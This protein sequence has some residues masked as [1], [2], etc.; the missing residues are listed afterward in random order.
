MGSEKKI[1]KL[2]DLSFID[3]FVATAVSADAE[4]GEVAN[5]VLIEGLLQRKVGKIK[6]SA[7][8]LIPPAMPDKRGIRFDIEVQEDEP[9]ANI[10]DLE[11]HKRGKLNLPKSNRFRQAKID[12]QNME[13]GNNNFENLPNLY[14]ITILDYDLFDKDYMMYT[15]ENR[16]IE[17]PD[18]EYKDG[19]R[20]IYFNTK[21]HLGGCEAIRNLLRYIDDSSEGNVVDEA[22][23]KLHECVSKIKQSPEM[24]YACMKWEWYMKEIQDVGREEGREEGLAEGL[25]AMVSILKKHIKNFDELYKEII[26]DENYKD[27]TVEEVRK[28]Y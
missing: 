11:P 6:V 20:F 7:Q 22:T 4:V 8:K 23:R 10:Y 24:R 16:C 2:E 21:G 28:Y 3:D 13:S 19:L 12:A 1:R 18:L 27:V 26:S 9:V 17:L 5:R 15:F 25:K 14:V